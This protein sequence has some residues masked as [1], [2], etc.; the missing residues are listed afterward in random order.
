MDKLLTN[1]K[2]ILFLIFVNSI[3]IFI[4]GFD[5][6]SLYWLSGVDNLITK[7][8]LLEAIYKIWKFGFKSYIN[9]PWNLFDFLIV[10]ISF[11][12][13]FLPHLDKLGPL[14]VLRIGRVF[15]IFRFFKFIPN[16]EKLIK[17][18]RSAMRASIFVLISFTLYIF[19]VGILSHSLFSPHPLYSDPIT[20]IYT[21]VKV[22]SVEGWYDFPEEIIGDGENQTKNFLIRGYF[23]LLLLTGG[24]FG[25]SIVN[26]IFVNS[27][28]ETNEDRIGEI[29][30]KIDKLVDALKSE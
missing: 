5:I 9:D 11:P 1:D 16:I 14:L 8:F 20:S 7:I 23:V 15:K 27:M 3:V 19:I 24:I 10:M 21:T 17:G 22:F 2:F 30:K 29:S 28:M 6:P 12:S 4:N 25:L 13:I 26:S 18:V